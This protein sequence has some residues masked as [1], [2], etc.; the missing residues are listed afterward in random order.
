MIYSAG[1]AFKSSLN[2]VVVFVVVCDTFKVNWVGSITP[3]IIC[4]IL[5]VDDSLSKEFSF[6]WLHLFAISFRLE[7][8]FMFD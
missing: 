4:L 5:V 8:Y 7:I 3:P 1:V 2:S 6:E